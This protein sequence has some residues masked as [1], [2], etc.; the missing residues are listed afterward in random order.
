MKGVFLKRCCPITGSYSVKQKG[1][2]KY[3]PETSSG[4]AHALLPEE[5]ILRNLTYQCHLEKCPRHPDIPNIL[6]LCLCPPPAEPMPPRKC[7]SSNYLSC[8]FV[9]M[10]LYVYAHLPSQHLSSNIGIHTYR[11]GAYHPLHEEPF[12]RTLMLQ[13]QLLSVYDPLQ[14]GTHVNKNTPSEKCC[15][16]FHKAILFQAPVSGV[17]V[18][19]LGARHLQKYDCS[20]LFHVG[21]WTPCCGP[22][23]FR[24]T[25]CYIEQQQILSHTHI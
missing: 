14:G 1:V 16:C 13:K 18:P 8:V 9:P 6:L 17:Y 10:P 3:I 7:D 24:N 20:N 4:S 23:V 19:S 15:L 22:Y 2:N 11:S 25:F 5:R 21:G 12:F